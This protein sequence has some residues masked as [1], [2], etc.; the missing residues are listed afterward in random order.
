M[1]LYDFECRQCKGA[2]ERRVPFAEMD[3]PGGCPSCGSEDV[4]RQ[5]TANGNIHIPVHF[6][7]KYGYVG[8]SDIHGDETE[9]EM[10]RNSEHIE[11]L[12][13]ARSKSGRW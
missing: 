12:N 3:S 4:Q 10:A 1:P 9:R 2:F 5:F 11:P 6:Q 7:S 8:W 13:R